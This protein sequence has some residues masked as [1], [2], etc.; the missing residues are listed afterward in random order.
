MEVKIS[1]SGR[2]LPGGLTEIYLKKDL[3]EY[4]AHS[5]YSINDVSYHYYY[6]VIQQYIFCS[7]IINKQV[8]EGISK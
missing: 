7:V 6:Y 1:T 2:E 3:T 5:K 8:N 4:S